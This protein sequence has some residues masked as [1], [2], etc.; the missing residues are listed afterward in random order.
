ME[1]NNLIKLTLSLDIEDNASSKRAH[2]LAV[3]TDLLDK[4]YVENFTL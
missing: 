2:P 3:W 4:R 1:N